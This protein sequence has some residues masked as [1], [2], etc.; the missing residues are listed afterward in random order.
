MGVN[1]STSKKYS[2]LGYARC[3]DNIEFNR[4]FYLSWRQVQWQP[5][6]ELW[7]IGRKAC[8]QNARIKNNEIYNTKIL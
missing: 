4:P 6:S 8:G 2:I 5:G 3:Q 7:G 1:S